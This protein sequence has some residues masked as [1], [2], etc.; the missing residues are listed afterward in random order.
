[1]SAP[2]FTIR[3]KAS[4]VFTL[5]E[6]ER[7]GIMSAWQRSA[8]ESAVTRRQNI[9]VVGGTGTGK[10]TLANAIIDQ[11]VQAAPASI[12]WS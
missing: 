1:M 2:V 6:Y 12:V 8:I 3:R 5:G 7:Q 9:L 11:M 10:T 4:A